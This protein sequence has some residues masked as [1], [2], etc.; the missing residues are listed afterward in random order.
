MA[1]TPEHLAQLVADRLDYDLLAAKIAEHVDTEESLSNA[2][3]QYG[4]T[5]DQ[6]VS[7]KELG[8]SIGRP[9]RWVREHKAELGAVPLGTGPKPRLGFDPAHVARVMADRRL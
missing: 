8:A 5:P 3:G 4:S 1:V 7:A 2:V 9:A 6:L